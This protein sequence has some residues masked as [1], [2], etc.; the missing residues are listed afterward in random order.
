MPTPVKP[1]NDIAQS[2]DPMMPKEDYDALRDKYFFDHVAPKVPKGFSVSATREEFL[3][4]T[5]RTPLIK[6]PTAAKAG[7]ASLATAEQILQP[8]ATVLPQ[9]KQ[10]LK[11]T[12]AKR[13]SMTEAMQRDGVSTT[14]ASV[15]GDLTG[16][17]IAFSGIEAVTRGAGT[18]IGAEELLGGVA[19]AAHD[20]NLAQK[21]ARG[22]L[23][24]GTY[25]AL[26]S[27]DK[28]RGYAFAKGAAIGA[29]GEGAITLA[30]KLLSRGKVKPEDIEKE[31]AKTLS[32]NPKPGT[33]DPV[34][35][36]TVAQHLVETQEKAKAEGK[37][38]VV[39]VDNSSSNVRVLGKTGQGKPF[40]LIVEPY[41]IDQTIASIQ[42][43]LKGGGEVVGVLYHQD[44]KARFNAFAK[45]MNEL[46]IVPKME[47]RRIIT[48][49]G[50]AKKV[51]AVL[52]TEGIKAEPASF[53]EDGSM[54]TVHVE[55]PARKAPS[56]GSISSDLLTH[57][58]PDGTRLQK[59]EVYDYARKIAQL[60]NEKIPSSS[61]EE[62]ARKLVGKDFEKFIPKEWQRTIEDV[63]KEMPE[64]KGDFTEPTPS[65]AEQ[66]RLESIVGASKGVTPQGMMEARFSDG[67][68][69]LPSGMSIEAHPLSSKEKM[70]AAHE[71]FDK[72]MSLEEVQRTMNISINKAKSYLKT[73]SESS[74]HARINIPASEREPITLD[75]KGQ[76][77]EVRVAEK[78]NKV[79]VKLPKKFLESQGLSGFVQ[80]TDERDEFNLMKRGLSPVHRMLS[81]MG[82]NTFDEQ[83][84]PQTMKPMFVY[85]DYDRATIYH[86]NLHVLLGISREI[87]RDVAENT[88]PQNVA[89][90]KD[91]D[92]TAVDIA[93]GLRSTYDDIYNTNPFHSLL[94]EAFV[95]GAEA[96]RMGD[97]N[98][99]DEL[100]LLDTS[101]R[102]VIDMVD[103]YSEDFLKDIPNRGDTE[104]TREFE[105]KLRDLQRRTGRMR[106]ERWMDDADRAGHMLWYDPERGEFILANSDQI[107]RISAKNSVADALEEVQGGAS[108]VPSETTRFESMGL[109][110]AS[111]PIRA[112][113]Y[114]KG[115]MPMPE[116][117]PKEDRFR[118][119]LSATSWI[120]PTMDWA[121]SVDKKFF[122]AG[123]DIKFFD[124]M[125]AVDDAVRAGETWIANNH[126][127]AAQF[128]KG[129]SNQLKTMFE[130]LAAD[131]KHWEKMLPR[132][133]MDRNFLADVQAADTWLRKFKDETGIQ[134]FNYLRNDLHSLRGFNFDTNYVWRRGLEP[135][136][137]SLFHR[138]INDG[139]LNPQDAHAGRFINFLLREG[140]EQKF[141]D[142]ALRD[143]KK[144]LDEKSRDGTSILGPLK[145]PVQNYI[146]YVRGIPDA[147]QQIMMKTVGDFQKRLGAVFK[148]INKTL[149]QKYHLPEDFNYPGS[150]INKVMSLS[151]VAGI[152]LRPIIPIRDT[153]QAITNGLPI[154]G[155]AKFVK[156]MTKALTSAGYREAR[157]AGA[158]LGRHT[159]GDLYGDI[160]QEIPP[161][162]GGTLDKALEVGNALLSPSRWGHNLARAIVYHGEFDSALN[163]VRAYGRGAISVNKLFEE[164]S[165][166]FFPK[167]L[168]TE[169]LRDIKLSKEPREIARRIAL[170]TVDSILWAYRRGTQPAFLRT[171]LGR[172]FGQYGMWPLNYAEFLRKVG[173]K[174]ADHPKLAMR[175][176]GLWLGTNYA[177][178]SAL[179]GLGGDVGKWFFFSPAGY[180]GSPHM[181][182]A[183]DLMKAPEESEDGRAARKRVL[184]YPLNFVPASI[185]TEAVLKAM[186]D[187]N[188]S[189]DPNK[190][191][192]SDWIRVLGMRPKNEHVEDALGDMSMEDRLAYEAGFKERR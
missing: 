29:A 95:H 23:A 178:S 57:E 56:L 98:K 77:V 141:T 21:M 171:G 110:H 120:R 78:K 7:V 14:G 115:G 88:H 70:F 49:P 174:I 74:R 113:P 163:A 179:S 50:E 138:A 151:Y 180:S 13:Q 133:N 169:I 100:A 85:K 20:L 129:D 152:G 41:S 76:P 143:L 32:P 160:F 52:Q 25:E 75:K 159:V 117:S 39:K 177:A 81:R 64:V 164:T 6:H 84:Y 16:S 136:E 69:K 59:G 173:S 86:E 82:I 105:E 106:L 51:A 126:K 191:P 123:H 183:L 147:S 72:G 44:H 4:Q 38:L 17:A 132:F 24:F 188:W 47:T 31:V 153:M 97:K 65:E 150:I 9:A 184:E 165:M 148:E 102:H 87:F 45:A 124:K 19:A 181:Q 131:P 62:I 139:D 166:W 28:H 162:S 80:D 73:W 46:N 34:V 187:S 89:L 116:L 167:P 90:L 1:F 48:K 161:H 119:I 104:N 96:V 11:T 182:M 156:G 176:T 103:E 55:A 145:F 154:L 67:N 185:E 79:A 190:V 30:G 137:M 111:A 107:K 109:R 35:D 157:E 99:L 12:R 26:T 128:L 18:E 94:E 71:L 63:G 22:G 92:K 142:G 140:Y 33:L 61:K 127:E 91:T 8:M 27:E 58:L 108:Y 144:L 10:L 146:N 53:G 54:G 172:I 43:H 186:E 42:G 60:W 3:K 134:V 168:Q 175:A 2:F 114:S 37:P 36:K 83:A 135:K 189:L 112:V 101:I 125:K 66:V 68:E 40:T 170:E 130:F 192:S 118:G 158:L 149:P 15:L 155:P 122:N 5:E 121:A 93:N